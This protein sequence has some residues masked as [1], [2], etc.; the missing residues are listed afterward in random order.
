MDT[1]YAE[2]DDVYPEKRSTGTR[3]KTIGI[4]VLVAL[5]LLGALWTWKAV[6]ISGVKKDA[7][8]ENDRL[9]ATA[10]NM[11]N[12]T[13]EEQLRLLVKPFVWAVRSEMLRGNM[14]QVNLYLSELVREKHFKQIEIADPRGIIIAT[15]NKKNEG[16]PLADPTHVLAADSTAV[17]VL[18]DSSWLVSSPIMGFNNRLGTLLVNYARTRPAL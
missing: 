18:P 1:R 11:I 13:K 14:E 16:Q 10:V 2:T 6:E 12:E 15:T 9:R 3:N 8:R 17:Q 4:I 5:V 7:Q